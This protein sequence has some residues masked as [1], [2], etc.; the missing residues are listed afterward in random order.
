MKSKNMNYQEPP[1][2][3]LQDNI[4]NEFMTDEYGFDLKIQF[5]ALYILYG[6]SN[7]GKSSTLYQLMKHIG[8]H[9]KSVNTRAISAFIKSMERKD[10]KTGRLYFADTR[11]VIPY[12]KCQIA[13]STFGDNLR[14]C[15]E[16]MFFFRQEYKKV[17]FYFYDGKSFVYSDNPKL[18]KEQNRVL[19]KVKPII[20]FSACRTEGGAVDAMEY[21]SHF[22]L[23]HIAKTSWIRKIGSK[24][25]NTKSRISISDKK[26]A[27]D[28]MA[29]IDRVAKG[30]IL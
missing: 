22:F 30:R 29:S 7:Q 6:T 21:C 4:K 23:R 15:E 3:I 9:S 16:N 25:D 10:S 8:G 1:A 2:N 20:F 26:Y 18:T 14:V 19:K 27:K 12:D 11:I 17:P 5:K 28:L 13:I 24:H